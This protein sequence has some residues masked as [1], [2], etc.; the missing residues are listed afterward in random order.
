MSQLK[1]SPRTSAITLDNKFKKNSDV[2]D[3]MNVDT[4]IQDS[5]PVRNVSTENN[6]KSST[7]EKRENMYKNAGTSSSFVSEKV[8]VYEKTSKAVAKRKEEILL[9]RHHQSFQIALRM[10]LKLLN[11]VRQRKH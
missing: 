7:S 6:I 10:S 5:L 1:H 2:K 4:T 11:F 3:K 9:A 8:R